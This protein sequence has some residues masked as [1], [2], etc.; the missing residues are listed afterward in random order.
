MKVKH[1]PVCRK[2]HS[3]KYVSCG[4][5]KCVKEMRNRGITG[6][7]R[8]PPPQRSLIFPKENV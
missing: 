3:R 1:C 5:P 8:K 4:D 2:E 6:F 7:M